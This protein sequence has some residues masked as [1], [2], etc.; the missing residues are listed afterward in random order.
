MLVEGVRV[1]VEV[2][3]GLREK[4][5]GRVMGWG[6]RWRGGARVG[7]EVRGGVRVGDCLSK[8]MYMVCFDRDG[9]RRKG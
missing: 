1:G 4:G 6:K 3:V 8:G 5:R 2:Q 9:V 7:I